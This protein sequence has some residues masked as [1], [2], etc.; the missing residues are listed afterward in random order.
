MQPALMKTLGDLQLNYLDLYLI[1]WP[2]SYEAGEIPL[3]KN[4]DGTMRYDNVSLMETWG[5]MEKLV[6]A[7]LVR[8][9]GLS[10]F[11]SQQV[12]EVWLWSMLKWDNISELCYVLCKTTRHFPTTR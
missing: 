7:G 8:H 3:P 11:N 10:N 5:A 4:E 12:D 2:M 1:H 6:D 9:I